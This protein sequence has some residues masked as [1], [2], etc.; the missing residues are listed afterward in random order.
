MFLFLQ[1]SVQKATGK[2]EPRLH[3]GQVVMSTSKV[4]MKNPPKTYYLDRRFLSVDL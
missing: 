1:K 3:P 4:W 2:V